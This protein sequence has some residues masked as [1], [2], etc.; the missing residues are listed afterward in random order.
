MG[1]QD[2]SEKDPIARK[3]T[4]QTIFNIWREAIEGAIRSAPNTLFVCAAGNSNSDTG[5]SEDVPASL[6]LP[7]LIAVG[8]V[9]QAGEETSFTSYG[10]TVVVDANGFQVESYVPGGT[11]LKFSGTSMSSPNVVNLAGK[12][13]ALDPSLDPGADHRPDQARCRSQRRWTA[14][15]HQSESHDRP[16]ESSGEHKLTRAILESKNLRLFFGQP[17]VGLNGRVRIGGNPPASNSP[18]PCHR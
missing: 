11:R 14:K 12:L 2:Q 3:K 9:D 8:A 17:H 18:S 15:P 13:I 16:A 6:H 5:F 4:A 10:A 7:N 1:G